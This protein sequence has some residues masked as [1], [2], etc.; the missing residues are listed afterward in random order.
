MSSHVAPP[1]P[2]P[3]AALW[4]ETPPMASASPSAAWFGTFTPAHHTAVLSYYTKMAVAM[5]SDYNFNCTCTNGDTNVHI[6]MY[7][8]GTFY[9]CGT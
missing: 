2:P 3:S 5:D 7:E 8:F 9:G 6:Y 1:S 4:L